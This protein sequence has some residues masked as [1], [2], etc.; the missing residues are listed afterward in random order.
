M[1][2]LRRSA[3]LI[4]TAALAAG[5]CSEPPPVTAPPS[6]P[7]SSA[8]HHHGDEPAAGASVARSGAPNG[9]VVVHAAD[10][11]TPTFTALA[12]RFEEAYPGTQ[13]VLDFGTSATHAQHIIDGATVDVFAS[14]DPAAT[15]RVT[16][17]GVTRSRPSV[18]ALDPLVIAVPLANTAKVYGFADLT[19]PGVRVA[20]CTEQVLCGM[21]ARRVLDAAGVTVQPASV[22]PNAGTAL[23]KVRSGGVDAALVYRTDVMASGA[24]LRAVDFEQ[25]TSVAD[26]YSVVAVKAGRNVIGA[27]AFVSFVRS[28]LARRVLTEAGFSIP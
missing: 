18:I 21:T 26:E 3:A 22:E 8:D 10:S 12:A 24:Q 4:V 5:G 14:A 2:L 13:V 28:A 23:V 6:A 20:L 11:L 9:R 7:A 25:A 1:A 27:S 15:A 19:R 16:K 17:A